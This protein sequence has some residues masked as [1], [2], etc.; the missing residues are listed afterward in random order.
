MA[1]TTAPKAS[2]GE[3]VVSIK[4]TLLNI[5]PPVWRR[6]LIPNE[7][8]LADLHDAIQAAMGW[9]DCHLH[10]FHID[11]RDYGD[12]RTVDDVADENRLTLKSIAKSGVTRFAYT[13]DFGDSWEHSV[14]IEKAKPATLDIAC[15]VCV[16]GKRACPPEDSG[17]PWGYHQLLEVLADPD[18]PDYA[19]QR[20]WV[21]EDL[22]PEAF[23]IAL[24]NTLIKAKF[25]QT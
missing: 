18:H 15:P 19:E 4:V 6:L 16:G 21:G 2:I 3:T 8:T 12:R 20:E 5:S 9:H 1:K 24:A 17:G 14:V 10:V 23:E 25:G 13:Y 11:G 22:D 7:M